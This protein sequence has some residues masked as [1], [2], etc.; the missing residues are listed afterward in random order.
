MI[1]GFFLALFSGHLYVII[2]VTVLQV[3]SFKEV[4]SIMNVPSR[5]R[6]LRFTK[7]L[8]WYFLGCA[9]YF[10]YGESVIYYFKHILLVDRVLLPFA[11]HHRFISFMLYIFGM[12]SD[13]PQT[14]AN[15][16]SSRLCLLRWI[17]SERSLQVPIHYVCVDTHCPLPH[18]CPGSLCHEQ[19]LRRSDLVLPT[20]SSG[21][22][23]RH[24]G[25]HLRYHLW[26]HP[27]DQIVT[28]E[29]SRR[30]PRRMVLHGSFRLPVYKHHDS[31]HLFYMPSQ[32]KFF[33]SKRPVTALT[34]I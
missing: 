24:L 23:K 7:S 28:K 8:N 27:I 3:V 6:S 13:S 9:M 26:P 20:C 1:A 33:Q 25:I 2:V 15:T 34:P 18:R 11:T 14:S 32:C 12:C 16:Y 5:S 29:D 19:H 4:V 30:L 21:H 31:L 22:H 10:L 17:A